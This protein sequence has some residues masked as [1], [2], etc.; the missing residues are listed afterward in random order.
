MTLRRNC[1]LFNEKG[2]TLLELIISIGIISFSLG[3]I[4][5]LYTQ[6]VE[7]S[8]SMRFT[9]VATTLA[10]EKMEETLAQDYNSVKGVSSTAFKSPFSDYI[11]QVQVVYVDEPNLDTPLTGKVTDYKKVEISVLHPL[12]GTVKLYTLFSKQS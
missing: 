7:D 8:T 9:S 11:Y 2:V 4:V 3:A 5:L 12:V 1:S 10:M 6:V